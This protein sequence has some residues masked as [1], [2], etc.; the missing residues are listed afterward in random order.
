MEDDARLEENDRVLSAFSYVF[1]PLAPLLL[2]SP[3]K[4]LPFVRYHA[5][6]SFLMGAGALLMYAI[7]WGIYMLCERI[8]PGGSEVMYGLFFFVWFMGLIVI[9][10][11]VFVVQLFF[12]WKAWSGQATEFPLLGPLARQLSAQSD[13]PPG[14]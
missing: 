5:M 10:L 13:V 14:A 4:D 8:Q 2:L 1:W 7:L 12:S 6:Q 11:L 9:G 3:R